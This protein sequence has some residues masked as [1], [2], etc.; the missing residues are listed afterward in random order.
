MNPID[1][2]R[3]HPRFELMAQVRVKRGR[4]DFIMDLCN[5]SQSG[6]LLDMG[7]LKTPSWVQT[8]R[9]VQIF[10]IHPEDLDTIAVQ[11]EIMRVVKQPATPKP[12]ASESKDSSS[13]PSAPAVTPD[14]A[15]AAAT[16]IAAPSERASTSFG[17]RFIELDEET[18]QNIE[19]LVDLGER[20]SH[21]PPEPPPLPM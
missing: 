6:A 12:G 20:Q 10:I 8:G 15:Q 19:R 3:A 2:R 1:E 14:A 9:V 5:I 7:S 11:G 17:V 21:L 13:R 16:S 18:R 4:V